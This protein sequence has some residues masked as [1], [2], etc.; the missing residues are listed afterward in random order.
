MNNYLFILIMVSLISFTLVTPTLINFI[1]LCEI[2][3]I[4]IY[5]LIIIC[6]ITYDALLYLI[7]GILLLCIAAGESVIGLS[8]LMFQFL[9]FGIYNNKNSSLNSNGKYF[10]NY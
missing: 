3:W 1:L 2:I 9:V 8:L 7:F 5:N 10:S 6:S 4:E